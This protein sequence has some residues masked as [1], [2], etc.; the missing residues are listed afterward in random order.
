MILTH[1]KIESIS[2]I[3]GVYWRMEKLISSAVDFV[4]E[5]TRI[6]EIQTS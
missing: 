4:L 6:K 3:Y 1:E 2:A 5:M